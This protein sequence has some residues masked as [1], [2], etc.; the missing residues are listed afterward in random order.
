M[1]AEQPSKSIAREARRPRAINAA[2]IVKA[3]AAHAV[4]CVLVMLWAQQA[5]YLATVL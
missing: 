4:S 2:P 3:P 5:S 1:T